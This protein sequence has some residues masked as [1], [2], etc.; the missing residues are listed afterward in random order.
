MKMPTPPWKTAWYDDH[1]G[2]RFFREM[3]RV[4]SHTAKGIET[5]DQ[6]LTLLTIELGQ[7][8]QN[9]SHLD[10][11]IPHP[12]QIRMAFEK[13]TKLASLAA[14]LAGA[15]DR[16]DP[17]RAHSPA[18]AQTAVRREE[19]APPGAKE[20]PVRALP[21]TGV[22]EIRHPQMP[23]RQTVTGLSRRGLSVAEI[24]VITDQARSQIESV[25]NER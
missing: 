10:R 17:A 7:L 11:E 4:E 15:L 6:W 13:A 23:L 19:P 16:V 22:E 3:S 1:V 21:T 8:A 9:L 5:S 18:A 24:E 20:A 14:Q 25:L 12:S 2:D